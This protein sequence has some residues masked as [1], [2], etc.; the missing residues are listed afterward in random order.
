MSTLEEKEAR[1]LAKAEARSAAFAAGGKFLERVAGLAMKINAGEVDIV[2][3][4]AQVAAPAITHVF[5]VRSDGD[6]E[7]M[8]AASRRKKSIGHH[9]YAFP[10][11]QFFDGH[12]LVELELTCKHWHQAIVGSKCW[13]MILSTLLNQEATLARIAVELRRK[14]RP[15]QDNLAYKR[16]Y[17]KVP[18]CQSFV[19][20]VVPG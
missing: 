11:E 15:E 4:I 10:D 14:C 17:F 8:Q 3:A 16:L 6:A 9:P 20:F 5:K 2:S 7:I 1:R 18:V 13:R 19:P 12:A